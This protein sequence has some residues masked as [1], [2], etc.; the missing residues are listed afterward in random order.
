MHTTQQLLVAGIRC[1][2]AILNKSQRWL[3][4]QVGVSKDAFSRRMRG[5]TVFDVQLADR[6]ATALGTDFAGLLALPADS[7]KKVA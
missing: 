7:M 1:R 6:V 3:A 2:L 4:D 5:E